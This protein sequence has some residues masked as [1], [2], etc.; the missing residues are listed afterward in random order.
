M[1]VC[2]LLWRKTECG[3]GWI[4]KWEY[5]REAGEDELQP[6]YILLRKKAIF[7]NKKQKIKA[8]QCLSINW[9]LES[10]NLSVS[11]VYRFFLYLWIG[12]SQFS[13]SLYEDLSQDEQ[14]LR[15]TTF[16]L[17]RASKQ[18]AG[19]F[20]VSCGFLSRASFFH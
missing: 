6:G 9:G 15:V 14:G 4:G 2:M 3:F 18:L 19:C 16:I 13:N 11:F 17:L 20:L 10:H 7:N 12:L 5:L 8:C 1:P